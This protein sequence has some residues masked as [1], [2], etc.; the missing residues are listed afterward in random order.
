MTQVPD[1]VSAFNTPR[2]KVASVPRNLTFQESTLKGSR[3]IDAP[4]RWFGSYENKD[5]SSCTGRTNSVDTQ[6]GRRRCAGTV[7]I[8]FGTNIANGG[9]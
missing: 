7:P 5:A 3:K 6:F 8:L 1:G 9:L 4:R 2:S